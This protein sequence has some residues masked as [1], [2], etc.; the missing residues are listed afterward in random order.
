M[1][2]SAARIRSLLLAFAPI[3]DTWFKEKSP[4]LAEDFA[5]MQRFM[6]K[7]N[8]YNASWEKFQ[9]L[10]R[11]LRVFKAHPLTYKQALAHPQ[12]TLSKYRQSFTSLF[13]GHESW[14][15]RIDSFVEEIKGFHLVSVSEILSLSYP[16][17]FFSYYRRNQ[18]VVEGLGL[19]IEQVRGMSPGEKYLSFCKTLLPLGDLYIKLV[20]KRS[21][22]PLN[23]ELD[24]FLLFASAQME[25]SLLEDLSELDNNEPSPMPWPQFWQYKAN[26]KGVDA[27]SCLQNDLIAAMPI[28]FHEIKKAK[29]GDLIVLHDDRSHAKGIGI[30]MRNVHEEANKESPISYPVF[31]VIRQSLFCGENFF[32][33]RIFTV[34][35]SWEAIQ[36]V[37]VKENPDWEATF[38]RLAAGIS[39]AEYL[40][41]DFSYWEVEQEAIEIE[42]TKAVSTYSFDQL[43]NESFHDTELLNS[44]F[45]AWSQEQNLILT[46]PPGVGKSFLA[47]RMAW[48]KTREKN[49]KRVSRIQF[50]AS[51]S[52][53][54]FIL[55]YRPDG[56]GNFKL[57]P[58]IFYQFCQQAQQNPNQDW[59]FIIEEINRANL[60]SVFGELLFLLE[61]DKRGK[62]HA[63][64]LPYQDESYRSIF[65]PQNVWLI[66]TMNK[67]DRSLAPIDYAWRR[68][69][70]F[71]E[72]VPEL[73]KKFQS[74]L[75]SL[76]LP[77]EL[78]T[79]ICAS[80]SKVNQEITKQEFSLGKHYQIGHSYLMPEQKT[81]TDYAAWWQSIIRFRLLPLLESYFPGD[82]DKVSHLLQILSYP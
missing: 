48:A 77:P 59:V 32:S 60:S 33:N 1:T 68:R 78:I 34:F 45:K 76:G 25:E 18:K 66:G 61:K 40:D 50:H 70:V 10:G 79:H 13:H 67:A 21:G 52:Y 9:Q 53:E 46:G 69:F 55:G 30:L 6:S 73:G 11:H 16:G 42:E 26:M 36:E 23:L 38:R 3:A 75:F 2:S 12:H 31:W 64:P 14:P 43:A 15:D 8:L 27:E 71:A 56:L 4:Q 20:G 22:L 44:L 62:A 41:E 28:D 49:S 72:L 63:T 57:L 81:I 51:Y 74:Y 82:S 35:S 47:A 24:Q 39:S 19:N 7:H 37:Y 54:D 5:F 17:L 58:G 80:L 65:V 29:A